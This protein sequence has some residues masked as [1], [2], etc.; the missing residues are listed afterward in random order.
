M[1]YVY[2]CVSDGR[3]R[4]IGCSFSEGP[5]ASDDQPPNLVSH[6]PGNYT[7]NRKHVNTHIQIANLVILCTKTHF[8]CFSVH[9]RITCRHYCSA[10]NSRRPP[11]TGKRQP[12]S[13]HHPASVKSIRAWETISYRYCILCA[14]TGFYSSVIAH[15]I[16]MWLIQ[17][18]ERY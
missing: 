18:Q 9:S 7:G 17:H 3:V 5:V 6:T 16:I 8:Y 10:T 4:Q 14:H 2:V 15:Y 11:L 1:V 12:Y 13:L